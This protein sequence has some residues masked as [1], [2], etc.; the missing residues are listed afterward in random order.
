MGAV[1]SFDPLSFERDRLQRLR[2][3]R[4]WILPGDMGHVLE[5]PSRAN[6][7]AIADALARL[8]A[9]PLECLDDNPFSN[10]YSRRLE[11]ARRV[12]AQARA[13]FDPF[14]PGADTADQAEDF[15][16]VSVGPIQP[17]PSQVHA[18]MAELYGRLWFPLQIDLTREPDLAAL[19]AAGLREV[20]PLGW[21]QL[22]AMVALVCLAKAL[23]QLESLVADVR[24]A[25]NVTRA[26]PLFD[27]RRTPAWQAR[28]D[29]VLAQPEVKLRLS[30]RCR[31]LDG[32]L[33]RAQGWLTQEAEHAQGQQQGMARTARAVGR[34]REDQRTKR[35]QAAR[36]GAAGAAQSK[37]EQTRA[38]VLQTWDR[39]QPSQRD[40]AGVT[41]VAH[42]LGLSTPTVRKHLADAG[43]Y[44]T[45]KNES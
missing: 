38:R 35:S 23:A 45:K 14:R 18:A 28:L 20:A 7:G 11:Q 1:Q 21:P 2:Q 31:E 44:R 10:A 42:Q 32:W 16:L 9:S 39:L 25:F 12:L 43:R 24:D 4:R 13:A 3:G 29:I 41:I 37:S 19:E 5:T 36:L 33:S 26:A 15:Q 17:L 40:G 22:V 30:E 8:R 6:G 34:L 27:G